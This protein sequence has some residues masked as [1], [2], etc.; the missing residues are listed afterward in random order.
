MRCQHL[1]LSSY[2]MLLSFIRIEASGNWCRMMLQI[3]HIDKQMVVKLKL[4]AEMNNVIE[5]DRCNHQV[6][7]HVSKRAEINP[8]KS[9]LERSAD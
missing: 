9:K 7:G 6:S 1:E 3:A 5:P 8:I 2:A 4:S